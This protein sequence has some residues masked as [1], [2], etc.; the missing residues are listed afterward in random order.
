VFIA[1]APVQ[2]ATRCFKLTVGDGAD[3]VKVHGWVRGVGETWTTPETSAN[4]QGAADDWSDCSAEGTP[5][6]LA[7]NANTNPELG[8][9]GMKPIGSVNLSLY[10]SAGFDDCEVCSDGDI[11]I[12]NLTIGY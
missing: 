9:D 1:N 7:F 8:Y 11:R 6:M 5:W 3:E 10:T 12:I 2:F 4:I